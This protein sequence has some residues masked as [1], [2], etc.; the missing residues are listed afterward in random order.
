[1]KSLCYILLLTIFSIPSWASTTISKSLIE[2]AQSTANTINFEDKSKNKDNQVFIRFF[3]EVSWPN[4]IVGFVLGII[5]V[6]IP[7]IQNYK[8]LFTNSERN[9]FVGTFYV[10]HWCGMKNVIREKE[11]IFHISLRGTIDINSINNGTTNLGYEGQIL[12]G[13]GSI[14]YIVLTGDRHKENALYVLNDP[15]NPKFKLTTGVFASIDFNGTPM[16]GK[17]I[18]SRVK[19][20][21]SDAEA[22]IGSRELLK[23]KNPNI[24]WSENKKQ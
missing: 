11:I 8:R 19:L 15:V 7:L 18:L 16:S 9:A 17:M 23:I 6:T 21:S 20:K 13:K 5:P 3:D 24:S 22:I 4:V 2:S 10:Y 1:M 14:V 12:Y